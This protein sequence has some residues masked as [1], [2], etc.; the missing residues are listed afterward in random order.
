MPEHYVIQR[1]SHENNGAS[2]WEALFTRL[3]DGQRGTLYDI[4]AHG[5]VTRMTIN[6][7]AGK[8]LK[9]IL[10]HYLDETERARQK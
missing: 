5:R 9:S 3:T 8:R 1:R 4:L 6:S 7:A 2:E 10:E